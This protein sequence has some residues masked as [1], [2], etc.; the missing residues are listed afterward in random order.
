M[1]S[2]F[3]QL[4][5]D[6]FQASWFNTDVDVDVMLTRQD[7]LPRLRMVSSYLLR[8]TFLAAGL[9][10][11]VVNYSVGRKIT[12]KPMF[13][14]S[15]HKR[16][17]KRLVRDLAGINQ[18]RTDSL[19][20]VLRKATGMS[21]EKGDCIINMSVD[22]GR[23]PTTTRSFIE[24][25]DGSRIKTP[26]KHRKNDN[27]VDGILKK[28]GVPIGAYVRKIQS[29]NT[30]TR[31]L[32]K[33]EDFSYLPFFKDVTLPSG[34]VK[35]RRTAMLYRAGTFSSSEST[36]T[37]P[38]LTP[39]MNLIR[40]YEDY[41]NTVLIGKR[42]SNA[43][44]AFIR[45]VNKNQ[46]S[47]NLA[48]LQSG[49]GLQ[50]RGMMDPGTI[51]NLNPGEDIV[52]ITPRAQSEGD[53]MF[54]QRILRLI[55]FPLRIPYEIAYQD[56]EKVNFASW[57][58][59]QI[60]MITSM[61]GWDINASSAARFIVNNL[62]L[63]YHI[64]GFTTLLPDDIDLKILFPRTSILD[65][66]KTSRSEKIDLVNKSKSLHGIHEE[67]GTDYESTYAER[68]TEAI[69]DLKLKVK[70]AVETKKAEEKHGIIL[71]EEEDTGKRETPRREGESSGED[72]DEEDARER[73]QSDG[74]T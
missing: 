29:V 9:R 68:V 6:Y 64:Q 11:A 54:S 66:E 12:V 10:E 30:V 46:T 57:K 69:D 16:L 25:I 61:T 14:K 36:R 53:D 26:P 28:N 23:K 73:R 71:T 67:H 60:E 42:V 37:L 4:N 59:G 35:Q 1:S 70:L 41:L 7:N 56:L 65:P 8:N 34:E 58:S 39:S 22:S 15:I 31:R 63:E 44:V 33:D 21:F 18:S 74:N 19:V 40:Y 51:A 2:D 27:V 17:Q 24:V 43:L 48:N 50:K 52:A 13:R 3:K 55:A 47:D 20:T 49:S 38:A 72:L 5:T 45:T 62:L 32:D